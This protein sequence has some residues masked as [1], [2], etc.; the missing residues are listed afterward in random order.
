MCRARVMRARAKPLLVHPL[1]LFHL[2]KKAGARWCKLPVGLL[3]GPHRRMDSND[4]P[5]TVGSTTHAPV[6]FLT[7]PWGI[8][9]PHLQRK[10]CRMQFVALSRSR[11]FVLQVLGKHA[12]TSASATS[13]CDK[14]P[15]HSGNGAIMA[16]PT[17]EQWGLGA[18]A[19]RTS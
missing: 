1:N 12:A 19:A 4:A 15:T 9:S 2:M 16:R 8:E 7:P 18:P 17:R 10:G 11:P 3:A 6:M 13:D 5:L 14:R